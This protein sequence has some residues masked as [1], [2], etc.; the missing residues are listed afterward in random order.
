MISATWNSFFLFVSPHLK[1]D[2]HNILTEFDNQFF[3][4]IHMEIAF[5]YIYLLVV[6]MLDRV[7]CISF[8]AK[9]PLERYDTIHS[10][11]STMGKL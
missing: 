10:S 11:P 6:Q 5:L 3:P 7:V 1:S 2:I 8:H 9:I 4:Q